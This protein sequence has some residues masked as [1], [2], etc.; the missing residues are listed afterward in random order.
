MKRSNIRKTET[1]AI[2]SVIFTKVQ[3]KL[4]F[5]FEWF[6]LSV[7][8]SITG[9][10]GHSPRPGWPMFMLFLSSAVTS[11]S[12]SILEQPAGVGVWLTNETAS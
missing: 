3:L 11:A 7:E 1:V 4:K 5:S 2:G 6:D 10:T 9:R 12:Y 8:A